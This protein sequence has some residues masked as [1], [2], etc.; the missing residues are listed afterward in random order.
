VEEATAVKIAGGVVVDPGGGPRI[1]MPHT[2][3]P[4]RESSVS[5]QHRMMTTSSTS[6]ANGFEWSI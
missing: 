2:V 6:R 5:D 3:K 1:S 4:C